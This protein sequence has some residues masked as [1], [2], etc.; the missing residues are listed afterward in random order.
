MLRCVLRLSELR[1][2]RNKF[3]NNAAW[4][5]AALVFKH[6]WRETMYP[7]EIDPTV[8]SLHT[9]LCLAEQADIQ[10]AIEEDNYIKAK[11]VLM[12]GEIDI[13]AD[14]AGDAIGEMY[15]EISSTESMNKISALLLHA[16]ENEK[17]AQRP[18]S[19]LL[20]FLRKDDKKMLVEYF[21]NNF[22]ED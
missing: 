19:D 22:K 20:A 12:S 8:Q 5:Q 18:I 10:A 13:M 2:Y 3:F 9:H 6:V 17:A 11:K 7:F 1:L 21:C 15:L 4:K 16:I 14:I